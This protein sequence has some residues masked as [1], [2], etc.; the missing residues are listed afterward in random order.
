MKDTEFCSQILGISSPWYVSSVEIKREENAVHAFLSY[1]EQFKNWPCPECG[2][3]CTIYDHREQR[4][5]RDLDSCH[6][7]TYITATL[8]RVKCKVH[9]VHTV[10]VPWSEANSHFTILFECLTIKILLATQVQFKTAELLKQSPD[11]VKYIMHKS[12]D[13]GM[14]RRDKEELIPHLSLDEKSYKKGHHYITVLSDS[15]NKRVID[16]VDKRLKSTT[17]KLITESLRPLQ[18]GKVKSVSMD[19]WEPFMTAVTDI[20]PN[21]DIVHDRFHIAK[22]L[23]KA[24]DDTRR[25][26]NQELYKHAD[27]TLNKTKYLWLKS[28]VKMTTKQLNA[29]AALKDLPLETAKVWAFKESFKKFFD[30]QTVL[31]AQLFFYQWYEAALLLKNKH[32]TKAAQTL[33]T[34]LK[35]LLAYATHRVTNASAEGLNSLI[36]QVNSNAKG[37]HKFSNLRIA[38]LFFLGKLDLYPHKV[39]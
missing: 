3:A 22:Y 17:E 12:V 35:G 36:Q 19:M 27:K 34:H 5:W 38:I 37:Y 26:E 28:H 13:R 14:E 32:L 4:T 31:S 10:R 23:N 7:K 20:L 1:E 9:G 33:Q 11:Q 29:F 16:I 24:V 6:F 21:A 25:D 15:T 2:T 39:P 18:R 8:P 30:C